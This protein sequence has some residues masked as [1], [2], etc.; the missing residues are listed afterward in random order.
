MRE[1]NKCSKEV[2]GNILRLKNRILARLEG[3]RRA[4]ETHYF[5]NLIELEVSPT[6]D[7]EAILTQEE[8]LCYQNPR[9]SGLAKGIGNQFSLQSSSEKEEEQN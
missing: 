7:L 3:I 5:K 6:K 9:G 1:V 4:L 2:S 8:I